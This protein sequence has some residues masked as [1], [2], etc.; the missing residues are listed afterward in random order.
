MKITRSLL[1]A[2]VLGMPGYAWL[3]LAPTSLPSWV[4]DG[5]VVTVL[6]AL[7]VVAL[8]QVRDDASGVRPWLLPL[9]AGMSLFPL[10]HV[11]GVAA[12]YVA[13]G[14]AALLGDAV[15]LAGYPFL[16]AGLLAALAQ[17]VRGLR[18]TVCLDGVSGALAGAAVA[19]LAIAPVL[20]GFDGRSWAHAVVVAFPLLDAVLV[21]AALG[22]LA[23]VSVQ[24]GRQF[25]LWALG[26][27]V[28]TVAH[29]LQGHRLAVGDTAGGG[30]VSGDAATALLVVPALALL[31]VGALGHGAM[32]PSRV[33][34]PR[35]LGVPAAA[36]VASVL[37]LA[38]APPWQVSAAPSAL[39]LG[40]LSVCAAR[41]VRAFL[42][43]RELAVVREMALTD[44]LTGIANRRALYVHLDALLA[45]GDAE[46]G[47]RPDDTGAFAVALIDLDHFK[48]VNDTLGHATG[49][50][51]LKG[52]VGRFAAAL[53]ELDTPHLFARLG[54]DEFAV[55]LHEA[56]TRNAALIV[57]QALQESLAEPL[58]LPD[59]DLHANASIGLAV[60]P[61]HGRTRSDILFAADAAMYAAK[62]SG[63]AVRFHVP[64]RDEKTQQLTLAEDLHRALDRRELCVEYQPVVTTDDEMVAVE[65][66]V[67]WDHPERGLLLPGEFLPAADRYRLTGAIAR[68]VLDVALGDL[69]RWHASGVRLGL[70]VNL[71]AADLRDESVVNVVAEA[72]LEHRLPADVLT[73]DISETA[74]GPDNERSAGV[75]LALHELGVH[76]ALDDYG[77]GGTSLAQLHE[78]PFGT[79][80]LDGRFARDT[81]VDGRS[82]GV[83]RATVDLAHAL[84]LRIVAEGVE[85]RRAFDRLRAL[86]CDLVQGWY[87]G[88]PGA[89]TDVEGRMAQP[90]GGKH[91]L[92]VPEQQPRGGDA[93]DA[94]VTPA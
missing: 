32:T 80:K 76:L 63:D 85:D 23:L 1:L 55:V 34:G 86:G 90:T 64:S 10:G 65:A 73:L 62:T 35:S 49:D 48:E 19:T 88:R 92:P 70:T 42:Q 75:V 7:P 53:E 74:L 17:H 78:L 47:D 46:P 82:E 41:F 36:S 52:V 71:S 39:A 38:A 11:V 77:T 94:R 25:G 26:L 72:L 22:A 40:A 20:T 2:L 89:A 44:E 45:L 87:T 15:T 58:H 57:G 84:G 68:R 50:A 9:T 13:P 24:H 5:L 33:P 79:V 29:T 54:G 83:V 43:L 56:T 31:A 3:L 59:A 21:A 14:P 61:L 18:M 37:V 67:R 27:L 60:A 93:S 8:R 69:S 66:L 81:A 28:L 30:A 4:R 6:L 16:L 51:L 12:S 91:R